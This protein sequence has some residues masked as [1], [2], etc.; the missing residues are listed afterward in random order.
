[1]T[2]LEIVGDSS[3]RFGW[4]ND[5]LDAKDRIQKRDLKERAGKE[6]DATLKIR[7]AVQSDEQTKINHYSEGYCYGCSKTDKVISTLIYMCG[8]CMDRRGTEGL[9]ALVTKKTSYELCDIHAGWV[10][11]DSWQIN[12]SLCDSCMRRLKL[13]HKEYR[14]KGGRS[15]APDQIIK[16]KFYARN[17]GEALGNG[18]TRDQTSD[19]RFARN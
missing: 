1:M 8:D 14:K 16:R 10:L 13:V 15:N 17:P 12:C 6:N 3:K 2:R 11:N 9:M 4:T 18:I 5:G 7:E 19:Q